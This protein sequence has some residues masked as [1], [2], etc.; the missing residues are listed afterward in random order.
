MFKT[1]IHNLLVEYQ[2]LNQ[3][4]LIKVQ[5]DLGMSEGEIESQV[6]EPPSGTA[7]PEIP[8][9]DQRY[10]R[11]LTKMLQAR[12]EYAGSWR[13]AEAGIEWLSLKQIWEETSNEENVQRVNEATALWESSPLFKAPL[14]RISLFGIH[15]EQGEAIYLL[16]PVVDGGEPEILSYSCN[17]ENRYPNLEQYLRSL[18]GD[19][20]RGLLNDSASTD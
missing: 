5:Q 1:L 18:I 14:S 3:K 8:T 13:M 16:W 2:Q 4:L 12:F 7:V 20:K 10:R 17:L 11:R 15:P 6:V 9:F 19:A